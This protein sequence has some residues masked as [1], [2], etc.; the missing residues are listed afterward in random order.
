MA[1]RRRGSLGHE[2]PRDCG[3][4]FLSIVPVAPLDPGE[5]A[6]ALCAALPFLARRLRSYRGVAGF[7]YR[8]E[9]TAVDLHVVAPAPMTGAIR[10]LAG[11]WLDQ[12][13]DLCPS[14]QWRMHVSAHAPPTTDEYRCVFWRRP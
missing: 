9:A 14:F 10:L 2:A 13:R 11:C 5:P 1:R 6:A 12:L 8:Q 3:E 7:L 4:A